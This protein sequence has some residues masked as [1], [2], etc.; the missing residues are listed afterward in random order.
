M[1]AIMYHYV[2]EPGSEY[3]HLKFLHIDSFRRQLDVLQAMG[4]IVCAEE[5]FAISRGEREP[6]PNTFV[7]TF[8]DGLS[9][10]YHYVLP[11]LIRRGLWG[12][13]Y[14]ST[15]PYREAGSGCDGLPLSVHCFHRLLGKYPPE[16]ILEFIARKGL[17]PEANEFR[18]VTYHTQH[19]SAQ[20]EL[21]VKRIG[22]YYA[23]PD[24]RDRLAHELV[25]HFFPGELRRLRDD[26]YM[27]REQLKE[28]HAAGMLVGS[29]TVTHPVLSRLSVERQAQEVAQSFT[30]LEALLGVELPHRS[31]CFPYGGA[32]SYNADTLAALKASHVLTSFDVRA[33]AVTAAHFADPDERLKLP[34]YDCNEF[35]HGLAWRP[36]MVGSAPRTI[37]VFTSNHPRHLFLIKL[38][39]D[40][41]AVTGTTVFAVLECTGK[42]APGDLYFDRVMAAEKKVFGTGAAMPPN[43]RTIALAMNDVSKLGLHD[44]PLADALRADLF[45]VYGASYIKGELCDF[46]VRRGA[47][48]LHAGVSPYYRGAAT[49]FWCCHDGR[50]DLIGVTAHLITKGL[51]SGA[52]LFHAVPRAAAVDPFELGMLAVEAGHRALVAHVQCGTLWSKPAQRQNSA[53]QLRYSKN[54]DFT[55]EVATAYL[56]NVMTPEAVCERLRARDLTMFV[57]PYVY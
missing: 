39:A 47:V 52:I 43:V 28:L 45:V 48:N 22:N 46:L 26:I 14:V 12:I 19:S 6:R 33:E 37:T 3:P 20:L 7:L 56:D 17:T 4:S 42:K 9:D 41:T 11:E 24:Q 51:D 50:P 57:N 8:D 40:A 25:E 55:P 29:H 18:N 34:R 49:N 44:H 1:R 23:D 30:D 32:H 36:L 35:A 13:F 38:L 54:A 53:L 10:H 15:Q 5:F 21:E 31:F 2:R 16:A 27:T